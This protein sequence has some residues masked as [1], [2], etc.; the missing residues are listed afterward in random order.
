MALAED[1]NE[2]AGAEMDG[3]EW[4]CIACNKTFRSEAAWNSHER[5]RKHLKEVERFD[6]PLLSL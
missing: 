6:S 3:E 2:W 5:S 4:E 1:D